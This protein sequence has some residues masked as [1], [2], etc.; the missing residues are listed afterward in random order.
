MKKP[1]SKA[2]DI[3]SAYLTTAHSG[4]DDISFTELKDKVLVTEPPNCP[5]CGA[6]RIEMCSDREERSW[7]AGCA[8]CFARGPAKGSSELAYTAWERRTGERR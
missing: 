5:F 3:N 1:Q 8:H 4:P 2:C 6:A 7:W